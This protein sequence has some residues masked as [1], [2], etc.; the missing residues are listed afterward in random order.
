MSI[1]E[2]FQGRVALVIGGGGPNMGSVAASLL[3]ARGAAVCVAD[4]DLA[5]AARTVS[6]IEAAG[7]QAFASEV[8]LR[9]PTS[10]EALMAAVVARH[11]ALHLMANFAAVYR[12][13]HSIQD[14]TP[15]EWDLILDVS[16]R[17]AF[18]ATKFA[19]QVMDDN[20]DRGLRESRGAVVNTASALAHRGDRSFVAYT[21]AKAG[22]LGLTRSA[23]I[24]GGSRKIRVNALCPGVTRTPATPDL[25]GDKEQRAIALGLL[26]F[27]GE[28]EDM[29][30]ATA[31]LLSDEARWVTG[32]CLDVDGGWTART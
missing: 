21:T 2:G 22:L 13:R 8:D 24:D 26:P 9:S 29:A 30:Y 28:A 4:I 17:G 31:W 11:G 5:A 25:E 15:D 7:G 1:D 6:E 16:L 14:Q 23:A 3:A 32:T 19:M 10:V 20:P 18:L 12:P 27:V